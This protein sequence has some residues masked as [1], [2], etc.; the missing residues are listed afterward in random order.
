MEIDR[1]LPANIE[2]F[3]IALK[4]TIFEMDCDR[5][6]DHSPLGLLMGCPSD[7]FSP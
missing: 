6:T 1:G 5:S 2:H 4:Y 3:F 7:S